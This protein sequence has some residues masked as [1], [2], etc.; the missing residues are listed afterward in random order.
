MFVCSQKYFEE[1]R[2]PGGID[3]GGRNVTAAYLRRFDF[4]AA[5]VALVASVPKRAAA[6]DEWGA[7]RVA[8]LLRAERFA[9]PP[10][11]STSSS[12]FYSSASSTASHLVF[13]FSSL[14]S[15]GKES[16]GK[17]AGWYLEELTAHLSPAVTP[18]GAALPAPS[19]SIVWPT[20][21]EARG[22]A[23]HFS[24]F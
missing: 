6:T 15:T 3:A 4:T 7:R 14:S 19:V 11:S 23:T 18:A 13:Q 24:R 22:V 16:A 5:K 12:S 10:P 8:K 21:E 20:A 2:W 17:R 1:T 9:P